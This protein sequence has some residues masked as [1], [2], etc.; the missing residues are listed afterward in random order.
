[1]GIPVFISK[2][3]VTSGTTSVAF[4]SGITSAY[5]EYMFVITDFHPA[6]D[7][8]A[9]K[10]AAATDGGSSYSLVATSTCLK[11]HHLESGATQL[12]YHTDAD[13]SQ[14]YPF[15]TMSPEVGADN[16]EAGATIIH[17]FAPASSTYVKHF[18]IMCSQTIS[19]PGN[20]HT[21]IAGYFNT[22]S[23]IDAVQFTAHNGNI[24]NVVIQMYGIK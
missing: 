1:M 21:L 23:D 6:I 5:D 8:N 4:T 24:D 13:T 10:M 18:I 3:V 15:F 11:A 2:Q 20:A 17:L 7:G 9:I 16:D 19:N 22:T 14:A 12:G